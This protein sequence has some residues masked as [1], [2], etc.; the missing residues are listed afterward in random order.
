MSLL[1]DLGITTLCL[2]SSAYLYLLHHRRAHSLSSSRA[3][4]PSPGYVLT[5]SVTHARLIP[6]ESKHAFTYPTLSLLVSLS[7]LE[8]RA[9]NRGWWGWVFGYPGLWRV[10]GLR[11][12]AYL[13]DHSGSSSIPG[14]LT[15][16][17]KLVDLLKPSGV[18]LG[19]VW[20]M[21]MPSFLGFEGIN[22]L[23]VYFC[24]EEGRDDAWGVVLEVCTN[25]I[26][27]RGDK[28]VRVELT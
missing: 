1:S 10:C 17:E 26:F 18:Q 12:E 19:E 4:L 9:L 7:A 24:Y 8:S 2:G 5:N 22:P 20:M 25:T 27:Q 14:P 23:T 28:D 13:V 21:T 15:I 16:R 11:P 6:A 3:T